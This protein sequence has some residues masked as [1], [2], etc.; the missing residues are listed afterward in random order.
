[1]LHWRQT[2]NMATHGPQSISTRKR[3]AYEGPLAKKSTANQKY[4]CDFLLNLAA[5]TFLLR[6]IIAYRGWKSSA[7]LQFSR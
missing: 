2:L 6:D 5:F 1:M 7:P 3:C 4:D